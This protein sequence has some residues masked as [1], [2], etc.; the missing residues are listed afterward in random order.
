MSRSKKHVHSALHKL[1]KSSI[2][3]NIQLDQAR[4]VIFS[5]HHRGKRDRADDFLNN[6][7]TYLT[8]L[9]HY[10]DQGHSLI[11]LGDVEEFWENPFGVVMKSYKEVLAKEQQFWTNERLTRI[12]GNHD[13]MWKVKAFFQKYLGELLPGMQVHEGLKLKFSKG[14]YPIGDM[15]LVHGHQGTTFSSRFAGFSRFFVRHFWR[16]LQS[17]FNIPLSTPSNNIRMKSSHDEIMFDWANDMKHQIIVCGHTHQPVFMSFTHADFLQSKIT[18]LNRKIN[19]ASSSEVVHRLEIEKE[20]VLTEL[21]RIIDDYDSTTINVKNH[22]KPCYFNSGCCSFSDG[23]ITGIEIEEGHI[24]LVKWSLHSETN[25]IILEDGDLK[26]I[27][28]ACH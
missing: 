1:N 19:K 3:K 23:D 25:R 8:A 24:R 27:F 14:E 26:K 20:V 17:L 7:S 5:D 12:W 6:E 28:A 2:E 18:A 9:N 10:Y 22:R 21:K 15:L 16:H 13:D 4:I 11:L